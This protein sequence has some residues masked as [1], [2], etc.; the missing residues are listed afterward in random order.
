MA[1]FCYNIVLAIGRRRFPHCFVHPSSSS[2]SPS[3]AFLHLPDSHLNKTH[4]KSYGSK[5]YSYSSQ[6]GNRVL[7]L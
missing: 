3:F 5:K 4:M 6:S 2:Y 7:H 1:F